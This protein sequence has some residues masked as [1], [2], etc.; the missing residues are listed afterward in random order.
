MVTTMSLALSY[1]HP[2]PQPQQ[3][4]QPQQHRKQYPQQQHHHL[5]HLSDTN[6]IVTPPS[7]HDSDVE[8]IKAAILDLTKHRA[9]IAFLFRKLSLPG[10]R[11]VDYSIK[12][13]SFADALLQ[14]PVEL[15]LSRWQAWKLVCQICGN[16]SIHSDFDTATILFSDVMKYLEL[17]QVG[18]LEAQLIPQI[19]SEKLYLSNTVKGD[20]IRL[21][22]QTPVLR[23]RVRQQQ[24]RRGAIGGSW[25]GPRAADSLTAQDVRNLL[26]TIDVDLTAHEAMFVCK[27]ASATSLTTLTAASTSTATTAGGNHPGSGL[28]FSEDGCTLTKV[29][30]YLGNLLTK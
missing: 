15:K 24:E 8:A 9:N 23:Q 29:V 3:Q 20:R 25:E 21:L 7:D 28:V 19:L 17:C 11:I 18:G 1:Y 26:S 12:C 4:Q 16:I 2:R 10:S 6:I 22:A 14:P 13:R 27:A 5:N 30:Y